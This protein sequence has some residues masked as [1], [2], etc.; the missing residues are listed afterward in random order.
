VPKTR[1][2]KPVTPTP[3]KISFLIIIKLLV[4]MIMLG[5][6]GFALQE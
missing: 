1:A 6:V 2:A 4:T 5:R 3:A